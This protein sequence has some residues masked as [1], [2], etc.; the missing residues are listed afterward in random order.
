MHRPSFVA[1]DAGT[2]ALFAF[3]P[4]KCVDSCTYMGGGPGMALGAMLAGREDA[5]CVTGDFSFLA[6]GILGFNEAIFHKI[7][8]KVIIFNNGK[9]HATGGQELNPD[10]M[11]NFKKTFKDNL[12]ELTPGKSTDSKI[13]STLL[14]FL[15]SKK[16]SILILEI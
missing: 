12:F 10:L 15:K 5:I 11:N 4:F 6:A 1:G 14:H 7:P 16:L 8:L 13:E 2:S 9:A 3:A